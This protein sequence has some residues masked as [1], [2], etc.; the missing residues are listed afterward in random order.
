ML[1]ETISLVGKL[2][3]EI[4]INASAEKFYKFFKDEAFNI[5][6][7][8]SK[9]VQQVGVHEGNWDTHSHDSIKI[10]N[11]TIDGK[12][13]VLKEQVEFDDEKLMLVHIGLEGNVFDHYKVFK[14]TYQVVPKNLEQNMRNLMMVLLILTITLSS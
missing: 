9:I 13:E 1:N 7:I 5:P 4:E 2:V 12:F 10:S 6:K 14:M 3:S 11:Y 8:S